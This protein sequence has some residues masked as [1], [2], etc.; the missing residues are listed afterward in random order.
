MRDLA[1]FVPTTMTA[2]I[3]GQT[4]CLPPCVCVRGNY[5]DHVMVINLVISHTISKKNGLPSHAIIGNDSNQGYAGV[6][7]RSTVKIS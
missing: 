2:M 6:L 1:I 3:D 7:G 5:Y 4:N